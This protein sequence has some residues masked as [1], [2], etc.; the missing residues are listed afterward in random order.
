MAFSMR[1]P[2]A[3]PATSRG[4]ASRAVARRFSA[5]PNE[6]SSRRAVVRRSQSGGDKL[7]LDRVAKIEEEITRQAR[8]CEQRAARDGRRAQGGRLRY[9]APAAPR[10]L[11]PARCCATAAAAPRA[12]WERV[13]DAS[14]PRTAARSASKSRRSARRSPASAPPWRRSRRM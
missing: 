12:L 10:R 4:L 5:V 1:C 13:A 14:L 6:A 3:L 11:P 8:A 9:A 2:L 7:D